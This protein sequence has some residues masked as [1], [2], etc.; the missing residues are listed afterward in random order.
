[1]T[2]ALGTESVQRGVCLVLQR[3]R[4]RKKK[5]NDESGYQRKEI[6]AV[7]R[8]RFDVRELVLRDRHCSAPCS[9]RNESTTA[10]TAVP[11]RD[12]PTGWIAVPPFL[13]VGCAHGDRLGCGVQT[14]GGAQETTCQP[15]A[16]AARCLH[17]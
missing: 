13:A 12:P 16:L 1:M 11:R 17:S 15:R 10:S 14:H 4:C 6:G 3:P 2:G 9:T 5:E 7:R 8:P